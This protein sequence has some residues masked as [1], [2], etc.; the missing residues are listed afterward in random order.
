MTTPVLPFTPIRPPRS[1]GMWKWLLSG[2]NNTW[3][4]RA[5]WRQQSPEQIWFE[6]ADKI[7]GYFARR[8]PG[9]RPR[10]WWEF[11]APGPRKRLGGVG[12]PAHE[13]S[14][15]APNFEFGIPSLW[16]LPGDHLTR[17][18]PIDPADPPRFESE[19]KYL[20]RL[21][22]L[23]PGERERLCPRDFWPELV[24]P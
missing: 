8:H 3:Y 12:T 14:A 21:G 1:L 19:A 5:I 24:E 11:N 7:V 4:F 10:L 16:R 2:Q 18:T 6:H 15:Y 20:R 23:L 22:L 9:T 17:G 13:C